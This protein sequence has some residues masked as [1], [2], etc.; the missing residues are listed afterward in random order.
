[1]FIP[2]DTQVQVRNTEVIPA[3]LY[4][5]ARKWADALVQAKIPAEVVIGGTVEQVREV[6]PNG[7]LGF[8]PEDAKVLQ[9]VSG[10]GAKDFARAFSEVTGAKWS[11][12][13]RI[14]SEELRNPVKY[15]GTVKKGKRK[16]E[17]VEKIYTSL[18]RSG[19]RNTKGK[20]TK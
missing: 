1:M 8:S 15:S 10:N 11:A 14:V 6:L 9:G 5:L 2:T 7:T 19:T 16:G 20:N 3:A 18:H 13:D 4:K 12:S 17:K